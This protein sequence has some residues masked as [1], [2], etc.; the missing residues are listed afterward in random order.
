M[1]EKVKLA[2][3]LTV[4]AFDAE[5]TDL[6][7]AAEKDLELVGIEVNEEQALFTQAVVTYCRLHFGSPADYDR[8]AQSYNEQK[9]QMISATGYGLPEEE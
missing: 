1:L 5:L 4:D 6:I 8:L 3:R 7:A 2:L 9:A